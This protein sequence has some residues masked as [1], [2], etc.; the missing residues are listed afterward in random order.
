MT[1][2]HDRLAELADDAPPGGPVPDLWDRG[3]RVHRRRQVGTVVIAAVMLVA[4]GALGLLDWSRSQPAPSPAGSSPAIPDRIWHPSPWLPG[5]DDAGELGQLAALQYATRQGWG[6][7]T[8]GVVGISATT[9]DYRFLDLPDSSEDEVALAPDGRH[10]AYWYTGETRLSPN[11]RSG[12]VVG[13]A[14]YDTTTGEVVR[15]EIP[16]DHGLSVDDLIWADSARLVFSY[17]QWRGGDADDDMAQ[18]S[19]TF[20]RGL[21]VWEP[22]VGQPT[23]LPGIDGD[24]ESATGRGQLL[25]AEDRKSIWVDLDKPSSSTVRFTPMVV[26]G[27]HTGAVNDAGTLL[28]DIPGNRNPNRIGVQRIGDDLAAVQTVPDSGR[29]FRVRAW[30]DDDRVLA[31]RRTGSGYDQGSLY[32]VDVRTGESVEIL[33]YPFRT[34]GGSTQLASDFFGQPTATR[35]EPPRPLDPRVVT[36][37]SIV[38]ALAGFGAVLVWRRRVRA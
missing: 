12:P 10:V 34:W 4:L 2:L 19:S 1:T 6:G 13:V 11:S 35:S 26:L 7:S 23:L 16:T 27:A 30:I 32:E 5:T 20:D 14:V 33:R 17:G 8:Y 24:V 21:F 29:T 38:V 15:H 31:D 3:R 18:S 22:A 37:V 36:G 25:I 9:G 28:A